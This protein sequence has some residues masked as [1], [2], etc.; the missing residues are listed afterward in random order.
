MSRWTI[1]G[2]AA[3]AACGG[4]G[5]SVGGGATSGAGGELPT[6]SSGV[7]PPSDASAAS[8][9]SSSSSSTGGGGGGGGG[10][11]LDPDAMEIEATT[12]RLVYDGSQFLASGT[13]HDVPVMYRSADGAAW[14]IEPLPGA[15]ATGGVMGAYEDAFAVG[16]GGLV[17]DYVAQPGDL[18]A[19]Y[20]SPDGRVWSLQPSSLAG[21]VDIAFGNGVF[22]ALTQG[23][24]LTSTDG[25]DWQDAHD[26]APEV[27]LPESIVFGAGVF[28]AMGEQTAFTT[29]DGVSWTTTPTPFGNGDL[30]AA[31]STSFTAGAFFVPQTLCAEDLC[32][33]IELL[34]STD[35]VAWTQLSNEPPLGFVASFR[36]ALY[37]P[38]S[39]GT[40]RSTDDGGTWQV[41]GGQAFTCAGGLDGIA[42]NGAVLV[43]AG[44]TGRLDDV[45]PPLISWSAD[46]VTWTSATFSDATP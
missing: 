16:A 10:G 17:V 22:V 19:V 4:A 40:W 44:R 38:R 8:S 2:C 30:S 29:T 5:D 24:A 34:R 11:C 28:V 6:S 31:T 46:G 3:L 1:V 27:E 42:T 39:I 20:T 37:S 12:T 14:T 36:G 13:A 45:A 32:P 15:G 9:S 23:S 21:A 33:P 41:S 25:V 7:V 26:F 18:D 43:R 35:G